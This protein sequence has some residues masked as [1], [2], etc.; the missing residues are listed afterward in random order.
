MFNV[1][2]RGGETLAIFISKMIA[3]LLII[4]AVGVG[5]RDD[6]VHV[7]EAILS[8]GPVEFLPFDSQKGSS[9]PAPGRIVPSSVARSPAGPWTTFGLNT[10][11]STVPTITQYNGCVICRASHVTSPDS[12]LLQEL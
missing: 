8:L 2:A 4:I 3:L 9:D 6:Y 11:Y 5:A 10:E 12:Q 1:Q 7:S